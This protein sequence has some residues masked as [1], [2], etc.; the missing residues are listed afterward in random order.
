MRKHLLCLV[1]TL[2]L[3]VCSGISVCAEPAAQRDEA[4]RRR[5]SGMI[6]SP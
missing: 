2:C 3:L 1:L 5:I 6:A 4:M